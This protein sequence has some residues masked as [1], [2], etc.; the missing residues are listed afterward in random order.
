MIKKK[1]PAMAEKV[2]LV[3]QRSPLLCN[4]L[5]IYFWDFP[6]KMRQSLNKQVTS[7]NLTYKSRLT[8]LVLVENHLPTN[9][10]CRTLG[11]SLVFLNTA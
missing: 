3:S 7:V 9:K 4:R 2:D 11:N 1:R 8:N 10:I 6:V 5:I